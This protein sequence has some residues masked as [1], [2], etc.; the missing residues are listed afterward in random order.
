MV[1]VTKIDGHGRKYILGASIQ[2]SELKESIT[3]SQILSVSGVSF[4]FLI[5]WWIT[6][7]LLNRLTSVISDVSRSAS[8][9][10]KGQLGAELPVSEI[11]EIKVSNGMDSSSPNRHRC[12]KMVSRLQTI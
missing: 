11:E 12:A 4:L 2:L 8:Q 1:L 6:G 9:M 3:E 7:I 5:F 10:A